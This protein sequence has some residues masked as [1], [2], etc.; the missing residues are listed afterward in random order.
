MNR[1]KKAAL[2]LWAMAAV[3]GLVRV[4]GLEDRVYFNKGVISAL[5]FVA[6]W[7]MA[8]IAGKR[9]QENRREGRRTF[10]FAYGMALALVFT[11]LL[12]IAM[13][14]AAGLPKAG[15][16][17]NPAGV[18][19]MAFSAAG[20]AFFLEPCFHWLIGF[21]AAPRPERYRGIR[22]NRVFLGS[23]LVL[24]IGYLPC[25]LAFYP[26]L[27]CYDI[28]WQ[29]D[30]VVNHNYS[31]HHPLLH[32]FLSGELLELGGR[33]FGSYNAG[34]LLHSLLQ[35]LLL[36]G[37]MAF[38]LRFLAKQKTHP[39]AVLGTGAFFLLFPF[40]PV[41][42]ISTTKD[43]VF[44]SLFLVCFT[45]IC[46]MVAERSFYRGRK[47]VAFLAVSVLMCLFR[48]NSIHGLALLSCVLLAAWVVCKIRRRPA[49]FL[50]KAAVLVLACVAISQGMY[51]LLARGFDATKGSEGEMLSLPMQQMARVYV[52][53]GEELSPREREGLLGYFNEEALDSYKY[54]VSDPVKA[55]FYVEGF[56]EDPKGFF[57][58]WLRLGRQFPG[59]YLAAPLYNMMGL[60]YLGGDSS[61]YVAF[62]NR[63]SFDSTVHVV[64]ADSKLPWLRDAYSWFTDGNIQKNLP[65]ISL[66]FYTAFYSWCVFLSAGILAAKRRYLSLVLPLFL[67]CYGFTLFFGPCILLRYFLCVI[68]CIPVLGVM[69]FRS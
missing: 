39:A 35:L 11:E 24:F 29:W 33:L 36:T 58:L 30:Q 18:A 49:S 61:C 13:R 52:R 4:Y 56:R 48:N 17:L 3:S 43:T 16:A 15:V 31:T 23:W 64:E 26:G 6:G 57:D 42:G 59:E 40:F 60:W 65:G 27:F 38:A 1:W 12:G 5:V 10:L 37:S 63:G 21:S 69:T 32:T 25:L 8:G 7:H 50:G 34:L 68:L 9:W 51:G 45:C 44:G 46:D 41:L 67:G 47:M 2:G 28:S 22:L 62:E 20:L 14:M 55:G 53:H 54:Y 66:I 19:W